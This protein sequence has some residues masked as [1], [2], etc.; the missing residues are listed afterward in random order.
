MLKLLRLLNQPCR[1]MSAL[2]SRAMDERL[3]LAERWACQLHVL[4][5]RACHRYLRDLRAVRAAL[6]EAADDLGES[7]SATPLPPDVSRRLKE[8]L[9]ARRGSE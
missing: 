8:R 4:Y 5:C 6:R 7:R 9:E 3:P 2:L 1:D